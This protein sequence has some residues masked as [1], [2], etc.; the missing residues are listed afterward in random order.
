MKVEQNASPVFSG[1]LVGTIFSALLFLT[2][3][4]EQYIEQ[5]IE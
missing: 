1:S 5:V 2:L 4:I 3:N